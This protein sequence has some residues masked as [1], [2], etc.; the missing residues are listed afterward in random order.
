MSGI[1][2]GKAIAVF[3]RELGCNS[4]DDRD[5]I[6]DKITEAI[7]FLMFNGGGDIL[8]EWQVVARNGRFTFPEDL[9]TPVKFKF[10]RLP[11]A[12]FGSFHSSYVS[13]SSAGIRNCCGYL[14]WS[15]RIFAVSANK[16][17]TEYYPPKCGVRI[18]ATTR[19]PRD[20]GKHIQVGGK[21][22]GKKLAPWHHN[23]KTSGEVL[24]IQ[25]ESDTD[26][27]YGAWVFDDITHVV[28]DLTCSYVMLSGID[29]QGNWF[30]LSH[31]HPD[32]EI[33]QYT[34][35]EV[36]ACPQPFASL[37]GNGDFKGCDFN[38]HILGRTSPSIRYIRNEDILPIQSLQMLSL[39]AKRARYDDTGDFDQVAIMEQRVK[40]LTRKIYAY[41][42]APIKQISFNLAGSGASLTNL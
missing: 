10:S 16:V 35:G 26:K 38:V 22:R 27:K 4:E 31:Y 7:E 33:P 42:Q 17:A 9:D 36:F 8:R 34:E 25:L 21:Q 37:F 11:N 32:E 12:G 40:A 24:P 19:D 2:L 20:V 41:Q 39:L 30:F 3:Q 23:V 13:Y 18:V 28:K 15:D 29:E 6:I 1:T 5:A 14:D